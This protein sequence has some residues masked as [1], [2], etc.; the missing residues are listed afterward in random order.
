MEQWH[1]INLKSCLSALFVCALVLG[2]ESSG[3][4]Q[5]SCPPHYSGCAH[6][7]C[8]KFKNCKSV[9]S[10]SYSSARRT[11]DNKWVAAK[12]ACEK[13]FPAGGKALERCKAWAKTSW[14]FCRAQADINWCKDMKWCCSRW[15]AA[16]GSCYSY[17]LNCP[18]FCD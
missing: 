4:M 2:Q 11:C 18:P 13:K 5:N 8:T 9:A 10:G 16:S 15:H 17:D 1:R 12:K 3:A 7:A 6:D 14:K